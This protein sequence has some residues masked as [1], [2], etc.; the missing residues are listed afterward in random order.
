MLYA[1]LAHQHHRGNDSVGG[2]EPELTDQRHGRLLVEVLAFAF[3]HHAGD[4]VQHQIAF[5][6][7]SLGGRVFQRLVQGTQGR[8]RST[9]RNDNQRTGLVQIQ[10]QRFGITVVSEDWAGNYGQQGGKGQ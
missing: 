3:A 4:A 9:G 10:V 2:A 7:R 6:E 1:I 5:L 8:V